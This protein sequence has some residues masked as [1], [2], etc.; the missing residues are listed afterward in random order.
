MYITVNIANSIEIVKFWAYYKNG[1]RSVLSSEGLGQPDKDLGIIINS[2]VRP[3]INIERWVVSEFFSKIFHK[4]TKP[5]RITGYLDEGIN[6]YV[7]L[8]SNLKTNIVCII[9]GKLFF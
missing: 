7:K 2:V 5:V 4:N 3:E 6:N 9:Y 8:K 1:V